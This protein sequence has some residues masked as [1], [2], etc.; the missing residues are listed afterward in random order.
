MTGTRGTA[1]EFLIEVK[2]GFMQLGDDRIFSTV[3]ASDLAFE[4]DGRFEIVFSAARP[5]GYSGNWIPLHPDTK[6][7]VIRQ[8]FL[9]WEKEIPATFYL[10]RIGSEGAAPTPLSASGMARILDDAGEWVEM[11]MKVWNQ[12]VERIRADHVPGEVVPAVHYVG[13]AKRSAMATT[14]TDSPRARRWSSKLTFRMHAT[15]RFSCAVFGSKDATMPTAKPASTTI[16]PPSTPT[17]AFVA[18]SRMRIPACRTGSTP[19]AT[20]KG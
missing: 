13:G 4:K 9:D 17:A 2:E 3:A 7:I 18:C 11:S 12:W 8:Y 14:T 1:F 19:P 20:S 15:G 6:L 5:S 10:E 16:R